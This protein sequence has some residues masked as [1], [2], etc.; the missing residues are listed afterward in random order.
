MFRAFITT[1]R[2]PYHPLGKQFEIVSD[3]EI[4]KHS[5][6]KSA[7]L[8]AQTVPAETPEAFAEILRQVG[9]DTHAAIMN[10]YFPGTEDGEPFVIPSIAEA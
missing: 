6:V 8:I 3:G 5:N 2:D 9:G 10:S 4:V 1:V 7:L